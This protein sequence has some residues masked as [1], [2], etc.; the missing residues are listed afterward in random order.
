[1]EE[2]YLTITSKKNLPYT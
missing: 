2:P 1:M